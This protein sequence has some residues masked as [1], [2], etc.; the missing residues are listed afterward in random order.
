[1]IMGNIYPKPRD[2]Y[3]TIFDLLGV[4]ALQPALDWVFLYRTMILAS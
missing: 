4:G 1:M 3:F 2:F